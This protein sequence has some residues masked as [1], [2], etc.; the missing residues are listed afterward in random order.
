MA[1]NQI[2]RLLEFANLQMA[3]EAFLLR[4]VDGGQI[5]EANTNLVARVRD[6]NF[7]ASRFTQV[8]AEK[9]AIDYEVLVQYRND[10]LNQVGA[11]FS[12]TLFRNR[13]TQELTLSFRSVEF[14][15]DAVRDATGTGRL[16]IKDLGWAFGQIAEMEAWYKDTLTG[17]GGPLVGKNFHVTGYSL[18]GHLATAF[19]ILRQEEA[20]VTPNPII[21]TYTFNG[22]GTG[23]ILDNRP[24]TDL[25]AN[26]NRI[27]K[28]Y[29]ASP[30]WTS[31]SIV[32]QNTVK[33]L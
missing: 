4:N 26:F 8:Q 27:R 9:L 32:E 24:L 33:G 18:G 25:L 12:G 6:G 23:A 30:E 14:I 21:D 20:A 13:K 22:A 10:P 28:N 17:P 19:N 16:E 2:G 31:L 5:S 15:D 3:A 1:N 11:G 7:H 29:A